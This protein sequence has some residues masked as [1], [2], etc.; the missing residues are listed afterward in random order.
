MH[1]LMTQTITESLNGGRTKQEFLKGGAYAV[2]DE[3]GQL[4]IG[5]GWAT[6][7]RGQAPPVPPAK[8]K[9]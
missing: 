7:A 3:I 9:E 2:P 4:W 5:R 6:A 8:G 1:I